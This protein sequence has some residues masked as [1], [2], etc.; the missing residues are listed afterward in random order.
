MFAPKYSFHTHTYRCGH[1]E[2]DI[3]DYIKLAISHNYF[4]LGISEHVCYQDR[5]NKSPGMSYSYLDNYVETYKS[6]YEK[7]WQKIEIH[8]GFECEFYEKC[9][10]Y[11]ISLLREHSIEYLICGQHFHY[12]LDKGIESYFFLDKHDDLAMI[13]RYRDDV[14]K[15]IRSGLFFYIAHPD[16]FMMFVSKYT[17][18][19]E[20]VFGSIIDEAIKYDLPLE[21]NISGYGKAE[22]NMKIGTIGHPFKPFWELVK[23]KHA[24]VIYGG[25]YHAFENFDREEWLI[26]YSKLVEEVGI[27]FVDSK[28]EFEKYRVRI[29]K[30]L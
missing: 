4:L 16:W 28:V 14:I 5:P 11:Y 24:K 1:A 27:E 12:S 18:E 25:D 26:K 15:A 3:E 19:I 2:G 17:P 20:E 29:K 23:K 30:F 7:Y 13:R 22:R 10:D 21:L 6:V 8:L 9:E